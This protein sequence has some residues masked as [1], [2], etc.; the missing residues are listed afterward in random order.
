MRWRCCACLYGSD[1]FVVQRVKSMHQ[2]LF[3]SALN[4]LHSVAEIERGLLAKI[5][6]LAQSRIVC[7]VL[8]CGDRL[9]ALLEG[10]GDDITLLWAD[11][12]RS[13]FLRRTQLLMQD[14]RAKTALYPQHRFMWRNCG[15]TLEVASFVSK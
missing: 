4:R 13:R 9:A 2:V 3:V 7:V 5:P 11:I 15:A 14:T 8:V 10:P 1:G 12:Q 6:K